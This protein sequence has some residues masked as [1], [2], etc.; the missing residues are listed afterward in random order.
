MERRKKIIILAVVSGILFGL[1]E[2]LFFVVVFFISGEPQMPG[3][4]VALVEITGPIYSSRGVIS[5]IHR[6]KEDNSVKAIVLRI[7][8][9]GGIV[10]PAQEIY[11]ELTKIDKEIVTSMGSIATSGG[12]YIACASDWIFANPGTLTGSIGVIMRFTTLEELFK[13][14]GIEREVIKSGSYKD[15]GSAYRKLTPEE[16]KLFQETIDDVHSQFI[17]A[18]FEGRKHKKLTREQIKEIA[19]GRV[20]SGKQAMEKK[21]IDQLGGLDDAIEYAGK[22]AGIE[23]KPRVIKKRIRRSLLERLIGE[24]DQ[25]IYNQAGLRYELSL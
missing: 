22:I 16:K 20:M 10:A 23:G 21:L 13:R 3:D 17:D 7:D 5:E 11:R 1:I 12:Y 14:F 9:P 6:Y 8:S 25:A 24:A 18:V 15:A 4:K 19:D 2:I